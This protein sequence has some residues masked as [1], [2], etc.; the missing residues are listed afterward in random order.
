MSDPAKD[1]MIDGIIRF[2]LEDLVS[3]SAPVPLKNIGLRTSVQ[4]FATEVAG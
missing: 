2:A 1:Q 3:W 4:K